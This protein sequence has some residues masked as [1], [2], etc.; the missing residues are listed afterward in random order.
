MASSRRRELQA[1]LNILR[2]QIGKIGEYL[3]NTDIGGQH[4]EYIHDPDPHTSDTRLPSALAR[5]TGNAFKQGAHLA[6]RHGSFLDV[7]VTCLV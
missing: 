1:R 3:R 4:F 7:M 2:F 5:F 6:A